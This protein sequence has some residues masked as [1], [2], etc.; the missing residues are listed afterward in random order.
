MSPHVGRLIPS[1]RAR[2]S[3]QSEQ[4]PLIRRKL[5]RLCVSA[6]FHDDPAGST[7]P[8]GNRGL[9]YTET[10]RAVFFIPPSAQVMFVS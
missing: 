10:E 9:I 1:Q 8:R 2:L 5:A 6:C 7:C 4:L 3:A